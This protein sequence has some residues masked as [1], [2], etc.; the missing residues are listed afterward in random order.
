VP[1]RQ[2]QARAAVEFQRLGVLPA[3]RAMAF[4]AL[5]A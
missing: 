4:F 3:R 2:R 5:F 1:T